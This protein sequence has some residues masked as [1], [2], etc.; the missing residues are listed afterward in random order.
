MVLHLEQTH[1]Y[2]T[3]QSF[4]FLLKENIFLFLSLR[5]VKLYNYFSDPKYFCPPPVSR[6]SFCHSFS[7]F[8]RMNEN[9]WSRFFIFWKMRLLSKTNVSWQWDQHVGGIESLC[10]DFISPAKKKKREIVD[11]K[12]GKSVFSFDFFYFFPLPFVY[13]HKSHF[14]TTPRAISHKDFFAVIYTS[15]CCNLH[16]FLV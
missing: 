10:V 2:W 12:V 8:D 6:I 13:P 5:R 7:F 15:F 9:I 11:A 16:I 3:F 14:D 4:F 1:K